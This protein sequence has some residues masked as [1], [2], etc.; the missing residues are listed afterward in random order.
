MTIFPTHFPCRRGAGVFLALLLLSVLYGCGGTKSPTDAENSPP[1]AERGAEPAPLSLSAEDLSDLGGAT[2][3]FSDLFS[4]DTP[5]SDAPQDA[6]RD[7]ENV[8]PQAREDYT[9]LPDILFAPQIVERQEDGAE[10]YLLRYRYEP[11]SDQKWNVSH[12]VWKKVLMSG[13]SGTQYHQ[14]EI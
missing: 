1:P 6:A 14:G 2:E 5:E 13:R 12:R 9:R 11:G 7:L 4:D 10:R 3:R 8:D